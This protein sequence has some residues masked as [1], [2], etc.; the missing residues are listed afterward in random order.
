MQPSK[1]YHDDGAAPS[2][3]AA[4]HDNLSQVIAE[5]DA[6]IAELEGAA[7]GNRSLDARIHLGIRV[8]AGHGQD[9]A[10][11]LIN[12]GVSWPTVEATLDDAIPRYTTSLD[13][14]LEGERI[15]FVLRSARRA[16]W[17]AMQKAAGEEVLGWAATE[18]LARRLAALKSW[19]AD[20]AAAVADRSTGREAAVPM[21]GT[22]GSDGANEAGVPAADDGQDRE[23]ADIEERTVREQAREGKDWEVL[24]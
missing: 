22:M 11:L 12:E 5:L 2:V 20:M 7:A 13:A 6:V 9:I 8:M 3:G 23:G 14:A 21:P 4:A 19:R 10:S 18:A 16:Q 1:P 17:V 24:F 15:V